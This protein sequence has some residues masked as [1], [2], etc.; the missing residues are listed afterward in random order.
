MVLG[1][2]ASKIIEGL[3]DLPMLLWS[4]IKMASISKKKQIKLT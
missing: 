1:H 2:T 3:N 4:G